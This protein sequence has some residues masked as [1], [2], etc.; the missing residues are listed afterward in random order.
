MALATLFREANLHKAL[1]YFND[2][3]LQNATGRIDFMPDPIYDRDSKGTN[4]SWNLHT[5]GRE[6]TVECGALEL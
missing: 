1:K 4:L 5:R 2:Y 6:A 3:R